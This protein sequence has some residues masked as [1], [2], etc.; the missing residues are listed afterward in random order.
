MGGLHRTL[1][2]IFQSITTV[3]GYVAKGL[4]GLHIMH[5]IC[6]RG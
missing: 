2:I 5:F 1:H 6:I 3:F 4:E